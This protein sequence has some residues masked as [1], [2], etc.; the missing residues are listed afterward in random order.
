METAFKSRRVKVYQLNKDSEWVDKGTGI[1]SCLRNR[2]KDDALIIVRSEEDSSSILLESRVL[3]DIDYQKQQ[4]TLIVWTEPNGSDLALS[5]QEAEGCTEIC[6]F[7]ND[8]QSH[9][10]SEKAKGK[11]RA[12]SPLP[13]REPRGM[14]VVLPE[15]T[16]ANLPEIERVVKK[17]TRS[18]Y[19]REKLASHV[20]QEYIAR[21]LPLLKTCEDLEQVQDLYRL[22]NI[23]KGF[24]MLQDN[25]IIR[26]VLRDDVILDVVG[27]LEYDPDFPKH[28]ANHREFLTKNSKFKEI[29]KISNKTIKAK[30]HETF[31]L[32][33]LKDAVFARMMDDPTN[34]VLASL[35]F[36]NHVEICKHFTQDEKFLDELFQILEREEESSE[37]K[38][39]VVLFTSQLCIIAKNI[40]LPHRRDLHKALVRN[41]ALRV[42]DFSLSN[43]HATIKAAGG[44]ILANILETDASLVRTYNVVQA[45]HK[46]KTL[47]ETIINRLLKD[48]DCFTKGQYAEAIRM[49][50]DLSADQ[51][52]VGTTTTEDP[53]AKKDNEEFI[54]FF[55]EHLIKKLVKPIMEFPEIADDEEI[56][57]LSY[58]KATL[59]FHICE[60]LSFLIKQHTYRSKYFLLSSKISLKVVE[61]LR[62]REGTVKLAA[63]RFIRACIG[64]K[65]YE[66][67]YRHFISKEKDIYGH[68]VRA[69][70]A[71]KERDNLINSACLEFFEFIR[72]ENIK[73]LVNHIWEKYRDKLSTIKYVNC[74]NQFKL[75]YEQNNEVIQPSIQQAVSALSQTTSRR[76]GNYGW[77]TDYMD[78]DEENYFNT[79]DDEDDNVAE[80]TSTQATESPLGSNEESLSASS[81][82]S[83]SESLLDNDFLTSTKETSSSEASSS[84]NEDFQFTLDTSSSQNNASSSN[85]EFS[86]NNSSF[87][88]TASNSSEEFSQ[89][90]TTSFGVKFLQ[91]N[92]LFSQYGQSQNNSPST[93]DFLPNLNFTLN[94]SSTLIPS[95]SSHEA[96]PNF[97]SFGHLGYET[98][99]SS[100]NSGGFR[101]SYDERRK[102][103]K[104]VSSS[105][106]TTVSMSKS[107]SANVFS[108][109]VAF[110]SSLS[111]ETSQI[112]VPVNLANSYKLVAP[113]SASIGMESS[114][115]TTEKEEIDA[116]LVVIN[117]VCDRCFLKDNGKNKE[118]F[119]PRITSPQTINYGL[120]D[121]MRIEQIFPRSNNAIIPVISSTKVNKD[122][123][124]DKV[125]RPRKTDSRALRTAIKKL[126]SEE[127]DDDN[128][129]E[130]DK[131]KKE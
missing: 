12:S 122:K 93:V 56:P 21:L 121:S 30:I 4:D 79:S 15:P 38:R 18:I 110:L 23:M 46:Q 65:D 31:R 94:V 14:A 2:A 47:A 63:L 36:I 101:M 42:F 82:T 102:Q 16:L 78:I 85:V 113:V 131:T 59:A 52:E 68:I 1:C 66:I 106:R 60:L 17:A 8:I 13:E 7:V 97:L 84:F 76:S 119:A 103:K 45:E 130:N 114:N 90:N 127:N 128:G 98:L 37:R 29:V 107:I 115:V 109:N 83:T 50:L 10:T 126:K 62:C 116:N 75:R 104:V 73:F 124:K 32:Q 44:D 91:N 27:C 81:S 19:E 22:C 72:K 5:F 88:D 80:S 24:I 6:T 67:I 33:Y 9:M 3:R 117:Q 43:N 41:G 39:D 51:T 28:K 69:L 89:A 25:D 54:T 92:V 64:T 57:W 26:Y 71:T 86:Q 96:V 55:Y 100:I 20:S 129:E 108:Y 49:L 53:Q 61:L 99:S 74:F 87:S 112:V 125:I 111:G 77:E 120:A 34:S 35:I 58:D 118:N 95:Y 11:R 123:K 40:H 70:L 105:N 48:R